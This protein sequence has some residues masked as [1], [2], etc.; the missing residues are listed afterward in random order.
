MG[1]FK[2]WVRGQQCTGVNLI[3]DYVS[4]YDS[5]C[6]HC[7]VYI[8]DSIE[9]TEGRGE[10]TSAKDHEAHGRRIGGMQGMCPYQYPATTKMSLA[11]F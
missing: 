7:I 1:R 8:Y 4:Q 5:I 3:T 10:V 11:V 2:G 6:L 9:L